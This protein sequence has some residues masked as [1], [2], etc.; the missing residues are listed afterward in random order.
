M[1]QSNETNIA[2]VAGSSLSGL[3]STLKTSFMGDNG[4]GGIFASLL[5]Q[6]ETSIPKVEAREPAPQRP[7]QTNASEQKSQAASSAA[8]STDRAHAD[9][10]RVAAAAER[11][12]DR[13]QASAASQKKEDQ[14]KAKEQAQ[15]ADDEASAKDVPAQTKTEKTTAKKDAVDDDKTVVAKEDGDATSV[16]DAKQAKDDEDMAAM[17]AALVPFTET[18]AKVATGTETKE[19]KAETKGDGETPV[20]DKTSETA[21]IDLGA[22]LANQQGVLLQAKAKTGDASSSKDKVAAT[23]KALSAISEGAQAQQA[24]AQAAQKEDVAAQTDKIK[25]SSKED[26]AAPVSLYSKMVDDTKSLSQGAG[27]NEPKN[28]SQ[29]FANGAQSS[30][31]S[32]VSLA[33]AAQAVVNAASQNG[34]AGMTGTEES[35]SGAVQA[36]GATKAAPTTL[37]TGEGVRSAGSYDFASQLSA[38]RVTKGGPAG[39]PQAVEQVA[40]QLNKAAKDGVDEITIQLRPA[41]LGKIEV[42][43]SFGADKTVTGTVIAENQATLDMLQKDSGSLQR[44]LQDAGLQAN[45]G[46]MEFS[47]RNDNGA[48]QFAQQ[49]GSNARTSYTANDNASA[50]TSGASATDAEAETYYLTPGRVNLR[51]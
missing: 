11:Q 12:E 26:E 29:A 33:A 20:A 8:Q 22:A 39:L 5:A 2:N 35:A 24:V 37:P 17:L 15:D 9:E 19:T 42:K 46:C 51:V 44:A 50:D 41:E 38:T 14:V 34:A 31:A 25:A 6:T 48:S 3:L 1:A 7:A 13:A 40:V 28:L 36:A 23:A 21:P 16:A 30:D 10:A 45:A 18:K 4:S 47:L 49:Q 27:A 43:L 32:Q